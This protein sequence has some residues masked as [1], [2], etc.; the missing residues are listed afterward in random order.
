MLFQQLRTRIL[1][2]D[3]SVSEKLKQH[4]IVYSVN[5]IFVDIVPQAKRLRLSLNLPYPTIKDPEGLCKDVTTLGR[6]GVGDVE[7]GVSSVNEFK[8]IMSLIRQAYER[9]IADEA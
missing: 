9:Q 5:T 3:A 2:L 7:V 8:Y 1:R 4:T 6:W